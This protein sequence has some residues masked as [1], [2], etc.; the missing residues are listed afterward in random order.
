MARRTDFISVGEML[1]GKDGNSGLVEKWRSIRI[2]N[3]KRAGKLRHEAR[4]GHRTDFSQEEL[5]L[6]E[7]YK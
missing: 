3:R 1:A 4:S 7:D 2:R 5:R 6:M